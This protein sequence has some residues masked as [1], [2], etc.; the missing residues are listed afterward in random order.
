MVDL[1]HNPAALE[2][3]ELFYF[4]Y[5]SFTALPDKILERRGLGR[6]HHRIL[7]FVARHPG[8]TVTSLLNT[9]QVTKQALN[10]PLRQLI[11]MGLV[12]TAKAE[13]D[14]RAKELRLTESGQQLEQ[15]LTAT[16]LRQLNEAFIAAGKNAQPGWHQIMQSVA[17]SAV[18]G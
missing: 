10:S 15:Q 2:S 17:D 1:N 6:V 18:Q 14:R 5:R 9:L 3:I 7:Y 4:A 12:A 16:Q 13:H 8:M 11:D